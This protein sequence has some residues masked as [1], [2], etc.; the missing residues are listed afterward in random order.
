MASSLLRSLYLTVDM[1]DV[2]IS[3][4]SAVVSARD[5][6]ID[7]LPISMRGGEVAMAPAVVAYSA[8]SLV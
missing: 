3:T 1:G 2:F 8:S 4:T 7:N 6:R 5:V